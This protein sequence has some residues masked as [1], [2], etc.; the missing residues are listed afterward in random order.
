MLDYARL[1]LHSLETAEMMPMS[2]VMAETDRSFNAV[3]P[4]IPSSTPFIRRRSGF[5]IHDLPRNA[6]VHLAHPND[7]KMQ[8]I[9]SGHETR[10]QPLVRSLLAALHH[11]FHRRYR[12][13][14]PDLPTILSQASQIFPLILAL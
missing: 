12:S 14:L 11:P 9:P 6:Q 7:R 4:V 3:H 1:L 2:L 5:I 10:S 13:L 8:P